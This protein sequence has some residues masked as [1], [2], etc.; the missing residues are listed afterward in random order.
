[1]NRKV[2]RKSTLI[3]SIAMLL[4]AVL[5]LSGVTYA[6][7]SSNPQASAGTLNMQSTAISGVYIAETALSVTTQ[8]ETWTNHLNWNEDGLTMNPSSCA[9]TQNAETQEIVTNF[10]KTTSSRA[11]GTWDKVTTIDSATAGT[12]Y[13]A[14]KIWVRADVGEGTKANLVLT[15]TFGG[16]K[17]REYQRVAIVNLTDKK[18]TVYSLSERTYAPFAS[19]A[20]PAKDAEGN[21]VTLTTEAVA[22]TGNVLVANYAG[23]TKELLV[24]FYFEGQDPDCKTALS[25]A[26]VDVDFSFKLEEIPASQG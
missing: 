2:M 12:D 4:V 25:Y 11:D 10:Y 9:F 18:T 15:I 21:D 20:G 22:S 7:F 14:K 6:W 16:E 26:D 24:Y 1:M 17:N 23:G 19:P 8:P 5:A 3:S 13:V